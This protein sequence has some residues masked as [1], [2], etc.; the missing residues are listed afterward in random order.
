MNEVFG[1]ASVQSNLNYCSDPWYKKWQELVSK[2]TNYYYIPNGAVGKEFTKLLTQEVT[3]LSRGNFKLERMIVLIGVV[4]QRDNMVK[5]GSDICR[6]IKHRIDMWN[7]G[8]FDE[9]FFEFER[10]SKQFRTSPH[11]DGHSIKIFSKPMQ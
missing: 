10:C 2:Q 5:K 4:F 9:L 8:N 3:L 11:T 6:L 1:A 7:N